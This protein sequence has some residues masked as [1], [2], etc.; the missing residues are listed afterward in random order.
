MTTRVGFLTPLYAPVV[1]RQNFGWLEKVELS[2]NHD[3]QRLQMP[4]VIQEKSV[5]EGCVLFID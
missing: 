4:V 3:K 2:Y 5:S 1:I